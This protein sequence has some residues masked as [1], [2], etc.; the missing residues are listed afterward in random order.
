MEENNTERLFFLAASNRGNDF[1]ASGEEGEAK[2]S[3]SVRKSSL[4]EV[5][6]SCSGRNGPIL[7]VRGV[8]T[9]ARG[10]SPLL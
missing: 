7:L 1:S 9:R 4:E 5:I 10:D 3:C 2:G 8:Y 6:A